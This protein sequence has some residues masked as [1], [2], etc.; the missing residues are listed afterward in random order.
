MRAAST[1]S[2]TADITWVRPTLTTKVGITRTRERA[3]SMGDISRDNGGLS[4]AGESE[5]R[6]SKLYDLSSGGLLR[7]PA[8]RSHVSDSSEGGNCHANRNAGGS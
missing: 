1:R 2:L 7:G 5:G 8:M 3:I 6:K 4:Q